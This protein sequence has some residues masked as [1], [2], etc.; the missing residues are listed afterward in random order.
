MCINIY[1]WIDCLYDL[2]G[3]AQNDDLVVGH[4]IIACCVQDLQSRPVGQF[5][6][7]TIWHDGPTASN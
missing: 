6:E 1:I 3:C 4:G 2:L 5:E 7:V